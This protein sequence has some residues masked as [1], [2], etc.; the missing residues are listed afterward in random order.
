M[1]RILYLDVAKAF[2]IFLVVLG[3][4]IVFH[5][6]L[7]YGNPLAQVIYSFHTALFMFLS[8]FFFE[9]CLRRDFISLLR[10]KSRQLLLPYLS[11]SF[12]CLIFIGIPEAGFENL[13]STLNG[14]I[15]G[16]VIR[17]YWYFKLLFLYIIVTYGFIKVCKNK[18]MGCAASYILFTILPNFSFSQI[19][20]PFFVGGYLTRDRAIIE[21]S[22]N[23][24]SILSLSLFDAV[25]FLLWKPEFN[26]TSLNMS[27]VP[28]V[29]R[30][31]I[32]IITSI[33]IV[34]LLKMLCG[35]DVFGKHL[36]K[37][38]FVG[39]L[40]LGIYACHELFYTRVL[41]DGFLN[42]LPQDNIIVH[43]LW[44]IVVLLVSSV[45]V[46]LIDKNKYLAFFFLGKKL[47]KD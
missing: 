41:W 31:G 29:V 19:F 21:K 11:W 43:L 2:A 26:Y 18:W 24:W 10:D 20:I 46:V 28:Y 8:G 23:W 38:A 37:I 34:L 27:F 40:T 44:S 4:V 22:F 25:L 1:N 7:S 36:S 12:V 5:D 6:S 35:M 30:T 32:G 17:Y 45:L 39:T 3:H 33:L 15:L 14:Y 42:L 47:K 9:S 16:G 13:F